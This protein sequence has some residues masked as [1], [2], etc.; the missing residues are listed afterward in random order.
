MSHQEPAPIVP[1][2]EDLPEGT[3]FGSNAPPPAL[4]KRLPASPIE[5]RSAIPKGTP[6]P[7][8]RP[9]RRIWMN[10]KGT[11]PPDNDALH[12]AMLAYI[13]DMGMLAT[14]PRKPEDWVNGFAA[15]LDHAMWFHRKPHF[16]DW[17]LYTNES[18]ISHN[19]RPL[20]F[21][22]MH[23]REG[24]TI[25]SVAQEG[26]MRPGKPGLKGDFR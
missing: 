21:G 1:M 12:A 22:T 25:A 5:M 13:S 19:A 23:T 3:L 20:I 11:L 18:P 8:G 10:L 17:V 16:D 14:L 9:T 26:L 6:Q 2:P 4:R 15:S 7:E 24:V